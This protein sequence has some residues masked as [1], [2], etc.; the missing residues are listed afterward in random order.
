MI[1]RSDIEMKQL[2]LTGEGI[3]LL[4]F[5]FLTSLCHQ[6]SSLQGG[7]RL[8]G[9]PSLPVAFVPGVLSLI[10]GN[11]SPVATGDKGHL[12]GTHRSF[13]VIC[14]ALNICLIYSLI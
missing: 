7:I 11:F 3:K 1:I 2:K 12:Q 5:P 9:Q 4:I 8:D 10:F 13:Q 14:V 6:R